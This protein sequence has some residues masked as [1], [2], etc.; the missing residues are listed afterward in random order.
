MS[1][2]EKTL[3]AAEPPQ[4]PEVPV[5]P[6]RRVNWFA[7]FWRW[8]FYGALLVIPVL[9]VL[10]I[11]GLTYLYR[12]Q[13][14]D[15]THPGVLTVAVPPGAERLPLA[16][17]EAAVRAAYPDRTIVSLTDN[18]GDRTTV[19]VTGSAPDSRNVYVDPYRAQVTGDLA[20][21][22]LVSDWAERIHG[23][24][25]IGDVGDR[26]VELGACWAIVL[27]VTGLFIFFLGR[28]P[29]RGATAK[30]HRGAR[31]RGAHAVI[32]LPVGLGLLLL[33][34]SGLPWTGLWGAQAQQLAATGHSSLWGDDPGA[35]SKLGPLIEATDGKSGPAGWA[36][37]N[38]PTGTSTGSAGHPISIDRAVAVA[39]AAGAPGP[40]KVIYPVD[41]T[42][43]YSVFGGQ[44]SNNGNPAES[45]VSKELTIHVDQYSGQVVGTYA[46]ADYSALAKTVSQGI[47]LH[48][49]R[50]FGPVNTM[51][52]TLFCLAVI[53]LC[54]SAPIMWWTRRG[55]ASG[56]AAP[57]ARLPILGSRILLV[58]LVAL[59]IFLPMFGLSLIVILALDQLLIR[60]VPA[61]AKFFGSVG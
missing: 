39:R 23:T 2:V 9:L 37:A 11:T 15:W 61:L 10:A 50:R 59:G 55:T 30:G 16:Q 42:G 28:R 12:A 38:G 31:L 6:G 58:A 45:D 22:Q 33:V 32:G 57:R 14:D 4:A 29:R 41:A 44:W 35:E 54:L 46:Y 5:R 18:T 34:V 56:V 8:H 19:F 36:V 52:T 21:D 20:P 51:L 47:A 17:Q 49:G 40:Y 13:V 24:L 43:V 53:F 48:E 3:P 60:R 25:L 1:V 27:T 7:A 26:I